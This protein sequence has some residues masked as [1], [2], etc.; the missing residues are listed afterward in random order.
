MLPG[1]DVREL[2]QWM[3]RNQPELLADQ[4]LGATL[5]A[6]G[7]SNLTY[8]LEG[9]SRPL[10]LRR[11]PLGHVQATAH[12][13][14]REFRVISALGATGVPV[15]R[16]VLFVDD[17]DAGVDAPFYLMQRVD[18]RPLTSRSDNAGYE[19]AQLRELSFDLVRTLA[20]LHSIVPAEIGLGDFGRPAGFLTRQVERWGTQY[21]GSRNRSLRE[22]D[23]LQQKLRGGIPETQRSSILHGDYR[24]DNALVHDVEGAPHVSAILDWEMATL[25][26]SLTDLGLLGLYWNINNYPDVPRGAVPS[27]V[28]ADDGYPSFEELVEEYSAA[29]GMSVPELPWYLAMAAFKLA[30]ILEG[31]H[32]RYQAGQTVGAGFDKIGQLVTPLA[33]TGLRYLDGP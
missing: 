28:W 4:P 10:V 5:I 8:T 19:P 26:D 9:T 12:D 27:S 1:L 17:P 18:G 23:E 16:A 14:Q 22:L 21:D 6:G 24:L 11:P 31:I 30:V 2:E 13:M 7:R 3:L 29:V 33:R 20:H 15:P 25:G 32:Y